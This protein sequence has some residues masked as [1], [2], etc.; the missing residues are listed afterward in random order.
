MTTRI[1]LF[2]FMADQTCYLGALLN[3]VLNTVSATGDTLLV[4]LSL[5]KCFYVDIFRA[6]Y[7]VLVG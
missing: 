6:D 2:D 4:S 3:L 7:F 1:L 5:P